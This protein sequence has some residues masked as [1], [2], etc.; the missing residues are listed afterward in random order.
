MLLLI[1]L[2]FPIKPINEFDYLSEL[3]VSSDVLDLLDEN[4]IREYTM[5]NDKNK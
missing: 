2:F 1:T 5:F 3:K 4:I